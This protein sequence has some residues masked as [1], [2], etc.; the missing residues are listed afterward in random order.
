MG[1]RAAA[2][3]V[4]ACLLCGPWGVRRDAVPVPDSSEQHRADAAREVSDADGDHLMAVRILPPIHRGNG[5]ERPRLVGRC[6]H[7]GDARVVSPLQPRPRD[8]FAAGQVL[9]R[10]VAARRDDEHPLELRHLD[11]GEGESALAEGLRDGVV[12]LVQVDLPRLARHRR[13]GSLTQRPGRRSGARRSPAGPRRA[14]LELRHPV[15]IGCRGGGIRW[16]VCAVHVRGYIYGICIESN[17]G[18]RGAA[19]CIMTQQ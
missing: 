3:D 6:V 19:M 11:G 2:K 7:G 5:G 17:L 1:G 4:C 9:R 14:W 18:G 13:Q 12:E 10:E 16:R 8:P 15:A